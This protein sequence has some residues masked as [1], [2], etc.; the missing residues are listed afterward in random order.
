VKP[1]T[2]L[3][4]KVAHGRVVHGCST[5]TLRTDIKQPQK[6]WSISQ[7]PS[8]LPTE[9]RLHSGF[10]TL[11]AAAAVCAIEVDI[12]PRAAN[13]TTACSLIAQRISSA[14]A[15]FYPGELTKVS[16]YLELVTDFVTWTGSAGYDAAI[17]HWYTSSSD[18]SACAVEPAT[19][20]DLGKIVS[21]MLTFCASQ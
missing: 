11:F 8:D 19:T 17:K 15:V 2:S 6:P 3:S 12:V 1:A 20:R 14:S 21:L 13:F 16:C 10:A 7:V 18:A 4:P 5:S 9:M